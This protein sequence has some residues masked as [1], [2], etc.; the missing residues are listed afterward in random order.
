MRK[1]LAVTAMVSFAMGATAQPTAL[2]R[3]EY[4][5]CAMTTWAM[6][7]S[8]SITLPKNTSAYERICSSDTM[9]F[10]NKET[11]AE[12]A[13]FMKSENSLSSCTFSKM[14]FDRVIFGR[15]SLDDIEWCQG[16]LYNNF[17]SINF[18]GTNQDMLESRIK[19]ELDPRISDAEKKRYNIIFRDVLSRSQ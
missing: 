10:Y 8:E 7:Y 15:S 9:M 5:N 12:T 13:T 18:S 14:S 6:S 11:G 16:E 19:S 3:D 17:R 1:F 2:T 4:E